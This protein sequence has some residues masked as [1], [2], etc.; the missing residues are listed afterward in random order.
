MLN[1][2]S[3]INLSCDSGD[4]AINFFSVLPIFSLSDYGSSNDDPS[5]TIQTEAGKVRG[6]DVDQYVRAW[7]GIPY[8]EPPIG[9]IG[10]QT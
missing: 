2:A 8:A 1:L 4:F 3:S 6:V 10:L 7:L 9:T 5:L